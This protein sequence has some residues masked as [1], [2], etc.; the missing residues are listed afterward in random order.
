MTCRAVVVRRGLLSDRL[1]HDSKIDSKFFTP[2]KYFKDKVWTCV[3]DQP[4]LRIRCISYSTALSEFQRTCVQDPRG[5]CIHIARNTRCFQR[6]CVQEQP[7][8]C[9]NTTRKTMLSRCFQSTNIMCLNQ[10]I[11]CKH[12]PKTGCQTT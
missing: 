10:V 5:Q 8:H 11:D 2:N 12:L 7:R 3:Q 9:I 1:K 4:R 6:T